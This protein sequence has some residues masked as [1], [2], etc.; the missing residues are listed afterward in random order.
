VTIEVFLF[1]GDAIKKVKVGRECST[2]ESD[3]ECS[4][5]LIWTFLNKGT[6]LGPRGNKVKVN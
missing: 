1:L 4:Y 6:I 5:R 3:E 2:N